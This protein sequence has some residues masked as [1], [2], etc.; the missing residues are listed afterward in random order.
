MTLYAGETFVVTHTATND[1]VALD[2]T[3]VESVT[4]TIYDSDGA[5]VV[6]ETEM[7]W[8]ATQERWEYVWDTGGSTPI[9]AGTYRAKVLITTLDTEN[10]EYRRIR[11]ARNPV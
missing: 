3:N 7:T 1:S 6:A 11:L 5:E 10:W 9:D 2:D 8:D 4:V